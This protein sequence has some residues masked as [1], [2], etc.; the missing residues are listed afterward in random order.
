MLGIRETL[1]FLFPLQN[2][3]FLFGNP[4]PYKCPYR[5]PQ[6]KFCNFSKEFPMESKW[7]ISRE[8]A[9]A[10][11]NHTVLFGTD[12]CRRG[13]KGNKT[14]SMPCSAVTARDFLHYDIKGDYFGE[15]LG[16]FIPFLQIPCVQFWIGSNPLDLLSQTTTQVARPEW[17]RVAAFTLPE[18]GRK[19]VLSSWQSTH[20]AGP[21]VLLVYRRS[22]E[23]WIM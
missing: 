6:V 10:F 13:S 22:R 4:V 3:F 17:I 20:T 7:S 21:V 15:N 19:P 1:I 18:N 2:N 23:K 9:A 16:E 8:V 11:L 5:R 14:V 12:G